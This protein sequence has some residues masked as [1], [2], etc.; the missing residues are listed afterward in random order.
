MKTDADRVVDFARLILRNGYEITEALADA[1]SDDKV[2]FWE[3]ARIG[4]EATD[5]AME[6]IPEVQ[7]LADYDIDIR[8]IGQALRQLHDALDAKMVANLFDT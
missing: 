3:G 6:L 7:R 5:L 8:D 2:T 1:L 4:R